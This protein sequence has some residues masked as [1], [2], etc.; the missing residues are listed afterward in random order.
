MYKLCIDKDRIYGICFPTT[1]LPRRRREKALASGGVFT[2][3]SP[4]TWITSI[5]TIIQRLPILQSVCSSICVLVSSPLYHLECYTPYFLK[6]T[7]HTGRMERNIQSGVFANIFRKKRKTA[8]INKRAGSV[9]NEF[10][11]LWKSDWFILFLGI[12]SSLLEIIV[13]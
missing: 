3:W 12:D 2:K 13:T 8:F 11:H 5:D 7:C 6:I 4:L 10:T 1:K 9:S